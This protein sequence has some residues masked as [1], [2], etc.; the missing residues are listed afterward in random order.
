MKG[1]SDR[2]RV[3]ELQYA[4]EQEVEFIVNMKACGHLAHWIAE[5]KLN[6]APKAAQRYRDKVI[7]LSVR[8]C[9]LD[10]LFSYIQKRLDKN[11]IILEEGEL[12]YHYGLALNKARAEMK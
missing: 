8:D 6:L 9:N 1:F 5:E 10:T 2:A 4:R 7:S 3:F 11:K 12:Q